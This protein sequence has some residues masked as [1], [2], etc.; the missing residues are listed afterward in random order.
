[1][2]LI[3]MHY[4]QVGRYTIASVEAA[5]PK[6]K[7]MARVALTG[8]EELV[9]LREKTEDLEMRLAALQEE[10]SQLHLWKQR[11]IWID[12]VLPNYNLQSLKEEARKNN[13]LV[14]GTKTQLLMRLVE[15]EVIQ[16]DLGDLDRR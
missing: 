15:A 2:L 10:N 9:E 16:P 13:L 14:G 3:G 12:E 7:A 4:F 8:Q 11:R 1:M 6:A 5:T